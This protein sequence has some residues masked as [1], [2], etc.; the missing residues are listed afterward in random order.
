MRSAL[1]RA[2]YKLDRERILREQDNKCYY[3]KTPLTTKTATMD[4]VVPV[5]TTKQSRWQSTSQC[6]VACQRCNS[7]KGKAP[8]EDLVLEDWEIQLAEGLAKLDE[9]TRQAEYALSF[10]TKGGYRKW[11]KYWEKRG[12]W[13]K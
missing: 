12:R 1:A 10:D 5:A 6:V 3:C 11:V 8:K 13:N 4:H 2:F 7:R 9:R